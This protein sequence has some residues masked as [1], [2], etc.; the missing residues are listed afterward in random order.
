MFDYVSES[1]LVKSECF[2]NKGQSG[3]D[4]IETQTALY[5]ILNTYEIKDTTY[6]D[7]S[8]SYLDLHLEIDNEGRL[9]T[10]LYDKRHDFNFSIVNFPFI[11]SNISVVIYDTYIPQRSTKSWWQP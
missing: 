6:A 9:R 11:C 10:K 3:M 5:I 2:F 4:D 1:V 8:A 7:R